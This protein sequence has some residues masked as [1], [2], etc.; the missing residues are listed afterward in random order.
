MLRKEKYSQH[1]P[2]SKKELHNTTRNRTKIGLQFSDSSKA[3][4]DRIM[5][6]KQPC[7]PFDCNQRQAGRYHSLVKNKLV[8]ASKRLQLI[9]SGKNVLADR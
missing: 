7:S 3:P 8:I 5:G 4:L 1:I 6:I 2:R 9:C